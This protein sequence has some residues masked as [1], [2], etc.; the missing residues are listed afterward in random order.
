MKERVDVQRIREMNRGLYSACS[1]KI[2]SSAP[3]IYKHAKHFMP[4][5]RWL[6]HMWKLRG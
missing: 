3:V 5:W 1:V 2:S 4:Y 6:D